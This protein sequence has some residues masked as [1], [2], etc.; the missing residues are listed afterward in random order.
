MFN[1]ITFATILGTAKNAPNMENAKM[2]ISLD[3]IVATFN[4]DHNVWKTKN[5]L[6][7]HILFLG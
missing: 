7:L 5:I 3:A 2:E 4:K 6:E 1:Y